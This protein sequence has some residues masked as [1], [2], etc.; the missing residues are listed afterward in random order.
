MKRSN[1][2]TSRV[3]PIDFSYTILLCYAR[4][5]SSHPAIACS[6]GYRPGPTL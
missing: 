1:Y 4:D 6:N 5:V 3:M 2:F